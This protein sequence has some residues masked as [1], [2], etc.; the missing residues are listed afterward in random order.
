[1]NGPTIW[2]LPCGSARRTSK[3][4]PRSRVRGTITSSSASQDCGSPRIGSLSGSQLIEHSMAISP[5]YSS[6]R[7]VAPAPE[8]LV[9]EHVLVGEPDPTSPGQALPFRP[10]RAAEQFPGRSGRHCVDEMKCLRHLEAG[11]M[12]LLAQ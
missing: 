6:S 2:R 8:A 11:E 10:Q 12:A 5:D 9:P 3:P 7:R 1:M 4:S